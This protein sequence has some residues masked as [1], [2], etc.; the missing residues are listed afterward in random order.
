MDWI[1]Q[2]LNIGNIITI[3]GIVFISFQLT[4]GTISKLRQILGE[5]DTYV[6]KN[7]LATINSQILDLQKEIKTQ[8]KEMSNNI[9]KIYQL[10]LRNK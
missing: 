9:M 10:M 5:C 2:Q 8:N 3:I 6:T 4:F 1:K 7:E